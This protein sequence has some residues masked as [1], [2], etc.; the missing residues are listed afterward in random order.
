MTTYHPIILHDGLP[1][2]QTADPL[3]FL[4]RYQAQS[5]DYALTHG[6]YS[7][8]TDETDIRGWMG[9]LSLKESGTGIDAFTV[10]T[11]ENLRALVN[12]ADAILDNDWYFCNRILL[13]ILQGLDETRNYWSGHGG[14]LSLVAMQLQDWL[15]NLAKRA[16]L[17]DKNGELNG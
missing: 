1:I 10:R 3:A 6:G 11:I 13:P 5:V 8:V 7:I 16:N 12:T 15:H 2:A 4:L 14:D 17:L 9:Y